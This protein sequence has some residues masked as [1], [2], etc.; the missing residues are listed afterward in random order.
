MQQKKTDKAQGK[1][2]QNNSLVLHQAKW[3]LES[4]NRCNYISILFGNSGLCTVIIS[5][6]TQHVYQSDPSNN[7]KE[8]RHKTLSESIFP[9]TECLLSHCCFCYLSFSLLLVKRITGRYLHCRVPSL[10]RSSTV[11]CLLSA[12]HHCQNK[13]RPGKK[14]VASQGKERTQW[15]CVT[16]LCILN[17]LIHYVRILYCDICVMDGKTRN[18]FAIVY[19]LKLSMQYFTEW[20]AS[21]HSFSPF[22]TSFE[23]CCKQCCIQRS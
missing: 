8:L 7:V 9:L 19:I 18:F 5:N 3:H 11:W 21:P 12:F 15:Q 13:H 20:G 14:R 6:I 23:L 1:N 17:L 22:H 16:P 10:A 2:K 4:M